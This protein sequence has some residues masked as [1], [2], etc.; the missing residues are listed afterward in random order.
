MLSFWAGSRKAAD[1]LGAQAHGIHQEILRANATH[2]GPNL[3]VATGRISEETDG[4]FFLDYITG[5]LQCWVY[6]PRLQRFGAKFSTNITQQLPATKNAEYLLVTGDTQGNVATASNA[7][8][9][10]CLVYVVDV[11]SGL[12]AAYTMPWTR[13]A[14]SSGQFQE[15]PLIAVDGGQYRAPLPGNKVAKPPAIA[16]DKPADDKKPPVKGAPVPDENEKK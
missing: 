12:F 10:G 1:T 15:G 7:R 14:E 6:Y 5:N 3:A 9:A 2:G 8:P 16:K 4:I 13:A 11:K